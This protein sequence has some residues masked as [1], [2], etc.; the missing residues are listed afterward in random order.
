MKYIINN[1][2]YDK[3]YDVLYLRFKESE[4]SYGDEEENNIVWMKDI[5]DDS[6]TGLT[7]IDFCK[8]CVEKDKRIIGLANKIDIDSVTCELKSILDKYI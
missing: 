8:M 5:N 1:F 3:R 2:D 6:V 7:I 4:N